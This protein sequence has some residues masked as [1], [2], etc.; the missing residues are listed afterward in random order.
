LF[1]RRMS[2]SIPSGSIRTS[3]TSMSLRT[4]RVILSDLDH[5]STGSRITSVLSSS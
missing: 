1:F 2:G 4:V 3:T 5:A